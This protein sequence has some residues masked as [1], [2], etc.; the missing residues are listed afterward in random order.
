MGT[1]MNGEPTRP[2]GPSDLNDE[3]YEIL[4][5]FRRSLREFLTFSD[6]AAVAEGLTGQQ[7]QALLAI[8][9]RGAPVSIGEIAEELGILNH[10]T[11]GLVARLVERDMVRRW[12]LPEDRRRIMVELRPLGI[13]VLSR[14]SMQNLREIERL[15]AQL[16]QVREKVLQLRA[17]TN[18]DEVLSAASQK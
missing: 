4:A 11:V 10:S 8:R 17:Q 12:P 16:A 6:G 15:A 13:E 5:A 9:G 14:I 3:Q 1:E 7:H 18:S 2:D